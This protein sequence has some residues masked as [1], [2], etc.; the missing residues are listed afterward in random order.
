MIIILYQYQLGINCIIDTST[1]KFSILVKL[2][3]ALPPQF[4]IDDLIC[5]ATKPAESLAYNVTFP[6]LPDPEDFT[7]IKGPNYKLKVNEFLNNS[8]NLKSQS[9]LLQTDS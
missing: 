7:Y 3:D 6:E 8:T 5:F 1:D 4:S 2:Y 9:E